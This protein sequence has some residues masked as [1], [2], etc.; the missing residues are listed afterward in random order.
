MVEGD[1][2]ASTSSGVCALAK[3]VLG[4]ALWARGYLAVTSGTITDEM[5]Q[6]YIEGQEGQPI[7]D[8][9]QFPIDNP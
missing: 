9:S 1:Q 2:L 4:Q 6:E 8:D 5:V 7:H 3:G